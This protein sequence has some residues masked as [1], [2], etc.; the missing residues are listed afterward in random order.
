MFS[1]EVQMANKYRKTCSTFLAIKEIQVKT[2]WRFLLTPVRT[3]AIKKTTVG[4]QL[5]TFNPSYSGG[6]EIRR[7]TVQG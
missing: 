1:K 6:R 3:A 7:I 2:T 5:L 4:C